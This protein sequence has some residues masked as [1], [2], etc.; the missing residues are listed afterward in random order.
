M[1]CANPQPGPM[2]DLVAC[3]LCL[4][5]RINRRR[6]WTAR[7]LLE[8]RD[9][10]DRGWG[11]TWTTLTYADEN[12]PR[13]SRGFGPSVQT[14]CPSDC[15]LLFK[16]MRKALHGDA[17]H[18]RLRFG[19]VGEY[20]DETWR[21][22]YHALLFGP[23]PVWV[24]RYLA[25]DWEQRFGHTR[26]RQVDQTED[27]APRKGKDPRISRCAY[28]AGYVVKKLTQGDDERLLPGQHP[29]Y[30][31]FSRRPGIGHGLTLLNL[32][33]S[34]G[35][36]HLISETGDV[37][38]TVRIGGRKWPLGWTTRAWLREQMGIP[39]RG[40]DRLLPSVAPREK[41]TSHDYET[42]ALQGA[43]LERRRE[44]RNGA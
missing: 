5:C 26:T 41:P 25:N 14:L 22:H 40:C 20:G 35:G 43:K 38:Y 23:D 29:E 34:K 37:P 33:T 24:E 6:V 18:V 12:I 27:H 44:A 11:I 1:L 17:P 19:L 32:C 2:G 13:I 42:A 36:A 21:P 4:N 3:G 30:T 7:L 10:E 31:R 15:T 9:A 28:L 8:A 16:R 39:M